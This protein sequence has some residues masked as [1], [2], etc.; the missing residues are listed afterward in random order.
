MKHLFVVAHYD[1]EVF[2]CGGTISKMIKAGDE[3]RVLVI[4]RPAVNHKFDQAEMDAR[5]SAHVKAMYILGAQSSFRANFIDEKLFGES[6][7]FMIDHIEDAIKDFGYCNVWTHWDK[8]FNQ[9]HRAVAEGAEIAVR[10]MSGVKSLIHIEVPSATE[11]SPR[12][13]EPTLYVALSPEDLENKCEAIKCYT[14]AL[15]SYRDVGTAHVYARFR[16]RA[17]NQQNAEAFKIVRMIDE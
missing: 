10:R 8:D 14:T 17:I 12:A 1:D 13:F 3:V 6:F 9:D 4:C 15:S 2:S 16:G 7:V 5:H 11:S